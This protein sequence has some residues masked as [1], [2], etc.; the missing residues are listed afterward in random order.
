MDAVLANAGPI[1]LGFGAVLAAIVPAYLAHLRYRREALLRLQAENEV[2]FN[3]A[4]LGFPEFI[5]EWAGISL[6]FEAL[7]RDTEIDRIMLFRAWN[8]RLSPRWTTS[9]YQLRQGPQAPLSYIHFEL[10]DDYVHRLLEVKRS[11]GVCYK[12][13]DMPECAI[14]DVYL[15]EGVAA[16]YWSHIH[17]LVTDDK[18]STAITYASFSTHKKDGISSAT[19]TRCRTITGRLKGLAFQFDFNKQF[20]KGG[21]ESATARKS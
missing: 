5:D 8:G 15:L 17:A 3:R 10:D 14:K 1:M 21:A 7:L 18:G 12:T 13:I 6:E 16:S 2:R 11:G 19:Q 9:V 4:A 20:E